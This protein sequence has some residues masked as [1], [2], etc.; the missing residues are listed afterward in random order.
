MKFPVSS[1]N[2]K[3]RPRVFS[4]EP[5]LAFWF[6]ISSIDKKSRFEPKFHASIQ[7]FHFRFEIFIK[8]MNLIF[9][10]QKSLI[11]EA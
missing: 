1:R 8:E 4:F 11:D 2:F 5:K 3:L 10:T 7:I 6:E 9:D